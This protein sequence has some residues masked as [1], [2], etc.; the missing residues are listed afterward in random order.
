L[1]LIQFQTIHFHL[2]SFVVLLELN[3]LPPVRSSL[4]DQLKALLLLLFRLGNSIFGWGS[5]STEL[6]PLITIDLIP[7]LWYQSEL[8]YLVSKSSISDSILLVIIKNER[9][10]VGEDKLEGIRCMFTFLFEFFILLH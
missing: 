1:S 2:P 6:H 7:G 10:K 5:L 9:M 8:A 4:R 3:H